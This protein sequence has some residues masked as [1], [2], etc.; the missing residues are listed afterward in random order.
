MMIYPFIVLV[1]SA[2]Y[3]CGYAVRDHSD[4]PGKWDWSAITSIFTV[5]ASLFTCVGIA[6]ARY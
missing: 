4:A 6:I 2:S 5:V 3:L 1:A